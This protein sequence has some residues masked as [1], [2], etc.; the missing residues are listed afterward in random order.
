MQIEEMVCF[1]TVA[2]KFFVHSLMLL[3]ESSVSIC[4]AVLEYQSRFYVQMIL[5]AC[6]FF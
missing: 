1:A 2:V 3:A 6:N 4:G 5:E